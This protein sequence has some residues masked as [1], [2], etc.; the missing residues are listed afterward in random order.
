MDDR[1]TLLQRHEKAK[2]ILIKK[3][4]VM[5]DKRIPAHLKTYV[6]ALRTGL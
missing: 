6:H 3:N 5:M 2:D 1:E 4:K